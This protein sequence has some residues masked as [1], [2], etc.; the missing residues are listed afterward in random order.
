[1]D[2]RKRRT[3][4]PNQRGDKEKKKFIMRVIEGVME[5]KCRTWK[6][7]IISELRINVNRNEAI[8]IY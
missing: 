2:K 8:Q 5:P 4:S 3:A 1:M 6:S 7:L